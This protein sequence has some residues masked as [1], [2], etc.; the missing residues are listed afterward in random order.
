[1]VW[2]S[3]ITSSNEQ[4]IENVLK[5]ERKLFD[6]IVTHARAD[7]PNEC[8]GILTGKNDIVTGHHVARNMDASPVKYVMDPRDMLRVEKIADEKG[9]E[10]VAFYHSHTHSEAYPSP[11][12][13]RQAT[14]PDQYYLIVSLREPA[15]PVLRAFKIQNGKIA[16]DQ[17]DLQ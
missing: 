16:E 9:E 12:D 11:T 10:I 5:L 17:I 6:L 13:V 1:M 14:W 7:A 15:N 8:C 2:T 3:R 4:E